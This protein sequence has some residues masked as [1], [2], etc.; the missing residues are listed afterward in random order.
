MVSRTQEQCSCNYFLSNAFLF[1]LFFPNIYSISNQHPNSITNLFN[2]LYL[3]LLLLQQQC[4]FQQ[5][6]KD[7][8]F[9]SIPQDSDSS[10]AE[11]E[12]IYM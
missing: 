1:L 12:E 9:P 3:F 11:E 2:K 6:N 8:G 5:Q 7:D 10:E 4:Q